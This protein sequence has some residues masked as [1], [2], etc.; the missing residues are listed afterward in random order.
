MSWFWWEGGVTTDGECLHLISPR[1]GRVCS[2]WIEERHAFEM[3]GTLGGTC[4]DMESSAHA[5]PVIF[6][7]QPAS[8]ESGFAEER[9][10]SCY[11]WQ[12]SGNV[13]VTFG[14]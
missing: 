1:N 5:S 4:S 13:F 12:R 10:T 8:M 7:M 6:E 14:S 9:W 11:P 3:D 2:S